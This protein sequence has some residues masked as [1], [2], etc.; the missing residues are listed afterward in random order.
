MSERTFVAL[1]KSSQTQHDRE[2]NRPLI[3][4]SAVA[5]SA[6]LSITVAAK[7]SG[8][9]REP[10]SSTSTNASPPPRKKQYR[11]AYRDELSRLIE[12]AGL[13]CKN[14]RDCD[15]L[16][17][18]ARSCGGAAEYT[19]ISQLAKAQ[20]GERI[21]ELQAIIEEMDRDQ[22]KASGTMGICSVLEKPAVHCIKSRCATKAAAN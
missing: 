6:V 20:F 9:A 7:N 15:A 2:M 1:R 14:D 17:L 3:V 4:L 16:P 13:T 21:A 12:E 11:E 10:A 22:Q 18:G 8:N 5:L 19:V